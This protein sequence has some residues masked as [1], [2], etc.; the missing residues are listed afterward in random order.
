MFVSNEAKMQG[1]CHSMHKRCFFLWVSISFHNSCE[2]P[3]VSLN[4]CLQ[5]SRALSL[6][7]PGNPSAWH[8]NWVFCE[9]A[10]RN[11]SMNS[12]LSMWKVHLLHRGV[13]WTAEPVQMVAQGPGVRWVERAAEEVGSVCALREK[14]PR[15]RRQEW[16][17]PIGVP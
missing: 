1:N 7:I 8:R 4:G 6:P 3:G 11:K 15:S 5:D 16:K 14:E 2:R 13:Y 17:W 12:R 9:Q 10:H